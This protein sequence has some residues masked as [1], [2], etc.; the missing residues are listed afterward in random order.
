MRKTRLQKKLNHNDM[1]TKFIVA[2]SHGRIKNKEVFYCNT[3]CAD[4]FAECPLY[5]CFE[6]LRKP[7]QK[8]PVKASFLAHERG[9]LRTCPHVD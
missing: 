5:F 4:G 6:P 9:N 8:N 2:M 7:Q 1:V 3:S